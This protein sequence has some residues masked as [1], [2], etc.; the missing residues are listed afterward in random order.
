LSTG[1][2]SAAAPGDGQLIMLIQHMHQLLTDKIATTMTSR[3][4]FTSFSFSVSAAGF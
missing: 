2:L 1:A 4:A 3:M